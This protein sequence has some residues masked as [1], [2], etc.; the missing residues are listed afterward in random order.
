M[1]QTKKLKASSLIINSLVFREYIVK[2]K[3]PIFTFKEN[4]YF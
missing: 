3:T 2:K 4:T 1:L